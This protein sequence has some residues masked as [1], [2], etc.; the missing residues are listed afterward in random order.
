METKIIMNTNDVSSQP[1]EIVSNLNRIKFLFYIGFA[2]MTI[3]NVAV[4]F[5]TTD[6][7]F[8]LTL[9]LVGILIIGLSS[10]YVG[11]HNNIRKLTFAGILLFIWIIISSI[12]RAATGVFSNNLKF[13]FQIGN[14]G[15]SNSN[16]NTMIIAIFLIII[17][18]LFLGFA[19]YLIGIHLFNPNNKVK[20]LI[21]AYGVINSL[22]SLLLLAIVGIYL[23]IIIVPILG[24]VIYCIYIILLHRIPAE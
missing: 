10:I 9:D 22:G 5:V 2:I 8:P 17:G 23:K 24:I 7:R 11:N 20:Y 3:Q 13:G 18:S 21:I 4:L 14:S 19:I 12:W 1:V 15:S 16:G 6:I